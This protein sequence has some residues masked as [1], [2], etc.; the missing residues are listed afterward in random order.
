M[1]PVPT[2]SLPIFPS[3]PAS[4]TPTLPPIP[5]PPPI[6]HPHSILRQR[7]PGFPSQPLPSATAIAPRGRRD[8]VGSRS[9]CGL[10][11][12]KGRCSLG[13]PPP[14]TR[15]LHLVWTTPSCTSQASTRQHARKRRLCVRI[16]LMV[17]STCG[18]AGLCV[19]DISRT[20][21]TYTDVC[22]NPV[23]RGIGCPLNG[24][25][26]CLVAVSA[27]GLCACGPRVCH[28]ALYRTGS[29][30]KFTSVRILCRIKLLF[31]ALSSDH[32]Q[33]TVTSVQSTALTTVLQFTLQMI[34]SYSFQEGRVSNSVYTHTVYAIGWCLVA[35]PSMQQSRNLSH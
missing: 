5:H 7:S 30:I 31:P 34:F 20:R 13:T 32:R 35:R 9:C 19:S 22:L 24:A 11:T 18:E 15:Q 17:T 12:P 8:L 28:R 2:K 29:G 6:A 4:Y 33:S 14:Q 27:V 25:Q 3:N 10:A 16:R 21:M 1:L 23:A 26:W